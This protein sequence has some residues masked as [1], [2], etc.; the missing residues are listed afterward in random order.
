MQLPS[1]DIREHTTIADGPNPTRGTL[2]V[3]GLSDINW[4][5]SCEKLVKHFL[6][7]NGVSYQRPL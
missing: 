2:E 6:L 7:C 3:A 5:L 1:S 4:F